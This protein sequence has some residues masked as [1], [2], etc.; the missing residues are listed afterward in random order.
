M[1]VSQRLDGT[2]ERVVCRTRSRLEA[3][4]SIAVSPDGRYVCFGTLINSAAP[5]AKAEDDWQAVIKIVPVG[6]G[7]EDR[8]IA[9]LLR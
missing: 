3:L 2:D 8:T 4:H 1:L 7:D 6:G 5:T 9:G